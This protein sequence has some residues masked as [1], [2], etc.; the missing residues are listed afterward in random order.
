MKR[1][2]HITYMYYYT[3][4][5]PIPIKRKH[6]LFVIIFLFQ[7]SPL[8]VKENT[9]STDIANVRIGRELGTF[10][11]VNVKYKVILYNFN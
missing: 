11:V 6:I 7:P 1:I 5:Q 3:L 10:G 9:I 2:A 4:F 8:R